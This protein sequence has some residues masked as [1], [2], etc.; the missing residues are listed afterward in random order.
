MRYDLGSIVPF[1]V[2]RWEDIL[3]FAFGHL[4]LVSLSLF[5]AVVVS[6]AAGLYSWNRPTVRE[7]FLSAANTFL[8]IP[9]LALMALMIP[10]FGLGWTPSVVALA[11]YSMMPIIRNTVVGLSD[12]SPAIA[13]SAKGMGMS[14][15]MVLLR[16]RL[17]MA[18]PVILAGLRVSAQLVVGVAT[19]AAYVGGP[20]FGEYLFKGLASLGSRDALNFALTGTLGAILIALVIDAVLGV[21]GRVTISEGIREK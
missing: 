16:V 5:V 1:W 4:G 20:G 12:V 19:I 10:I 8:T 15:T 9:S 18:W 6:L 11:L 17:P 3:G 21:L 14:K 7:G 2:D 13:E